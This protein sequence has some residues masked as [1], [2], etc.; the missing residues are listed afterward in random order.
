L[1]LDPEQPFKD[2]IG[3]AAAALREAHATSEKH[4]LAWCKA[5]S[6]LADA[7]DDIAELRKENER[8]Q[9]RIG[10]CEG[11]LE[12]YRHPIEAEQ[13]CERLRALLLEAG[14]SCPWS[15]LRARINAALEKTK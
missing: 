11:A 5:A 12:T 13:E 10:E 15:D 7:Q 6:E 3:D 2:V 4:R 8:L 1:N 9:Q 14:E